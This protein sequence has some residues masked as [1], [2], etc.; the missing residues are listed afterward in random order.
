MVRLLVLV[1][2]L[3]ALV[4]LPF[5]IWGD[6]IEAQLSPS[7]AAEWMRSYGGWAWAVGM[8]LI[9]A[10]I[11]LPIPATAVMAALGVVYGP[12]IGGLTATLGSVLAGVIGYGLCRCINRDFARRLAGEKG[13]D[14]AEALFHRWGGWLVAASRWA[15]VLPETAAFMA[16][17]TRMP[18]LRFT[19]AL[20][21]GSAPLG[22]IFAWVGHLGAQR[23]LLT[24]MFAALAPLA[25]WAAYRAVAGR[26]SEV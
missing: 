14:Q 3:A 17:L 11:A 18:F 22:F 25:L 1:L 21:C 4:A 16:G 15:P 9:A 7:G 2:V 20:V 24:M 19:A 10:D 26:R 8:G 6:G 5:A 23:P 13:Y 12:L